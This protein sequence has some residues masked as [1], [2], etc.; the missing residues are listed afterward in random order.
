M[1][2]SLIIR[3]REYSMLDLIIRNKRVLDNG[4]Y[5]LLSINYDFRKISYDLLFIELS[6]FLMI[7]SLFLI[8]RSIETSSG[9]ALA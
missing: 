8:I 6:L 1:P 3:N 2:D 4:I 7:R 9:F 5:Y